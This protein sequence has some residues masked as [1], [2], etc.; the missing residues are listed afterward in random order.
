MNSKKNKTKIAQNFKECKEG[1]ETGMIANN[2][3]KSKL[4]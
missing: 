2:A 4:I 1:T 3:K